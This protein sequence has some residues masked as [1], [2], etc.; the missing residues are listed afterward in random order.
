MASPA[1]AG[2]VG[3]CLSALISPTCT[4]TLRQALTKVGGRLT[5]LR[6]RMQGTSMQGM[7]RPWRRTGHVA[8]K[9]TTMHLDGS[10]WWQP[11]SDMQRQ[12]LMMSGM[13]TTCCMQVASSCS[14]RR[15]AR[16]HWHSCRCL[17]FSAWQ[18][19]RANIAWRCVRNSGDRIAPATLTATGT[20]LNADASVACCVTACR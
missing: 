15:Y 9:L 13:H 6:T 10:S 7:L 11:C 3:L 2:A 14:K 18:V 5:T 1:V 20:R 8:C 19:E 17:H 12:N 4:P 16:V